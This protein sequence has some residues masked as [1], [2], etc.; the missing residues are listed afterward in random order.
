MTC[1]EAL[2]AIG[3]DRQLTDR[4]NP[5]IDRS[6]VSIDFDEA[7][8][9]GIGFD[10][11]E[12]TVFWWGNEAYFDHT[13]EATKRVVLAHQN[14]PQTPPFSLLFAVPNGWLARFIIDMAS[15]AVDALQTGTGLAVGA[16]LPV[17]LGL[18]FLGFEGKNL[19]DG[20]VGFFKD[21]WDAIKSVGEAIGKFLGLGCG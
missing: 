17:P 8:Q 18:V 5:L 20:V 13:L 12:D 3:L 19:I 1:T 15:A 6:R 16:A 10:N 2:L 14:L 21:V 11:E 7:S 9:W 4:T